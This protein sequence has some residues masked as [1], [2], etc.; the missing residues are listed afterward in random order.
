MRAMSEDR[1]QT[2]SRSHFAVTRNGHEAQA[3]SNL[4]RE[5][6]KAP[7]INDVNDAGASLTRIARQNR[8][9]KRADGLPRAISAQAKRLPASVFGMAP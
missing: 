6:L 8:S 4:R 1:R 3:W 2:S 7:A 5:A 9:G